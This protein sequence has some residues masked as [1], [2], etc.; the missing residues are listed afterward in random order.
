MDN[1]GFRAE[2]QD[3]ILETAQ[4]ARNISTAVAGDFELS[5]SRNPLVHD[6]TFALG[7]GVTLSSTRNEWLLLEYQRRSAYSLAL[8]VDSHLDAVG[9]PDEGNVCVHVVILTVEGHCPL[10]L[11]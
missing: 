6:Q 1:V 7:R 2:C 9:D 3:T 11:A 5:V 10:N 8:E 4:W